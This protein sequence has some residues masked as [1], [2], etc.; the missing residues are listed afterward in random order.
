MIESQHQQPRQSLPSSTLHY[1][2][3][4]TITV[5]VNLQFD[6]FDTASSIN[7]EE[8]QSPMVATK[9]HKC[10][11]ALQLLRHKLEHE[12]NFEVQT[13]RVATNPFGEWLVHGNGGDVEHRLQMLDQY[14]AANGIDF[15]SL[16]P[17][18]SETL[19]L[20]PKIIAFSPRFFTSVNVTGEENAAA[21]ADV[22]L[23]ISK[24]QKYQSGLGNFRFCVATNCGPFIPFFPVAKSDSVNL[25]NKIGFALGLENGRM[26]NKL[27][28]QCKALQDVNTIFRDGVLSVL[29]P[30][31]TFC[32][33]PIEGNNDL[34]YLG[35]DTSL[36]PSLEVDGSVAAAVELLLKSKHYDLVSGYAHHRRFG[37]R[38]SLAV[39]A[40]IT[41]VL[42]SLGPT[43]KVVPGSY[44][45]LML[46][47]CED[48]RLAE[49]V[50]TN[51]LTIHHLLTLSSVC[52][53]GV[54]TVPIP[55]NCS[56]EDLTQILLDVAA[57]ATRYNKTLTCRVFPVPNL[58]EGDMTSFDSPFLCN[59]RVVGL[60]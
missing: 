8:E 50:T 30:I 12:G 31:D 14:L 27:L 16:G 18:T 11:T 48:Y 60:Y 17:S 29:T 46:P 54:D 41:Q 2:R 42:Q 6:D 38:G 53:V 24:L 44:C 25:S 5:F 21:A 37:E 10:S 58:V 59:T 1:V 56:A 57:L 32:K 45:G 43:I 4:R 15:C 26:A 55:G 34:V 28:S 49:L 36:N 51:S 13:L 23:Q 40:A 20:C 33:Q 3:I 52:G 22:I 39:V 9:I 47:V 35:M 7:M 19:H